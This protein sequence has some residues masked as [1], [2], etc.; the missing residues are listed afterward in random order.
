MYVPLNVTQPMFTP[1]PSGVSNVTA[2][3]P[4]QSAEPAV[5]SCRNGAELYVKNAGSHLSSRFQPACGSAATAPASVTTSN[6]TCVASTAA[7]FVT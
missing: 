2:S 5:G 3:A 4:G 6:F 7:T 1:L